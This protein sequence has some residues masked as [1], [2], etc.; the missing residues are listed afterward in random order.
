MILRQS[1]ASRV[2]DVLRK[3]APKAFRTGLTAL[4]AITSG[5][6]RAGHLFVIGG[7][8]GQGKSS[9]AKQIALDVSVD[10][11]VLYLTLEEPVD[12]VLVSV[13]AKL[14]KCS[15]ET[16]R[17]AG[18]DP[19]T[20]ADLNAR[21]LHIHK[22][23]APITITDFETLMRRTQCSVVVLD[24]VRELRGWIADGSGKGTGHVGPTTISQA[25]SDVA[26]RTGKLLIVLQQIHAPKLGQRP[27]L[28]D[29][30]DSKMLAQRAYLA[31]IVW[32]PFFGHDGNGAK[33][34]TVTE[35]LVLK[36]RYG[37]CGML[38]YRWVGETGLL[39]PFTADE[40]AALECC[41]PKK[42]AAK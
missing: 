20:L 13:T 42:S 9:L 24:H 7:L 35:L 17:R 3:P 8:T 30:M 2:D 38:H 28:Y 18:V 1:N 11:P 34:D 12:E 25:L 26:E 29:L 6:P 5:G 16:L 15:P 37:K 36:N 21:K 32:R 40:I 33:S 31:A 23:R 41:K 14:A 39:H 27:Q 19:I 4:D 22:P 10:E